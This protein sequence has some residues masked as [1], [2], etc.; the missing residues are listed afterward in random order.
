MMSTRPKSFKEH[1]MADSSNDME[2]DHLS[3]F[4]QPEELTLFVVGR[5]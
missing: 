2:S 4:F 5:P 1:S 3:V